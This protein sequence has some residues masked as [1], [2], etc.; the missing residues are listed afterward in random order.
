MRPEDAGNGTENADDGILIAG[1]F[2]VED[3]VTATGTPRF[4]GAR[5]FLLD[6]LFNFPCRTGNTI[7]HE[8]IH[9]RYE[10]LKDPEKTERYAKAKSSF[11]KDPKNALESYY[12]VQ[13]SKSDFVEYREYPVIAATIGL[14]VEHGWAL[15]LD[16]HTAMALYEKRKREKHEM[17]EILAWYLTG[18]F[19]EFRGNSSYEFYPLEKKM[20]EEVMDKLHYL[21]KTDREIIEEFSKY[22]ELW[23]VYRALRG[24]K[25]PICHRLRNWY[26]K[27]EESLN[28]F[29]SIT[30]IAGVVSG[31]VINLALPELGP[32]KPI[33]LL[34]SIGYF[35][36]PRIKYLFYYRKCF[37]GKLE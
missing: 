2:I 23:Q 14:P 34:S 17:D 29:V 31:A 36:V 37:S 3:G 21:K 13:T 8:F 16:H 26:K 35:L 32:A 18:A 30:S 6:F 9:K 19:S 11:K 33:I 22:E 12:D 1:F 7:R 25:I 24:T 4:R 27:R 20:G 10:I 28:D 15:H 5:D